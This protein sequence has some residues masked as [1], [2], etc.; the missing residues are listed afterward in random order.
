VPAGANSMNFWSI[1]SSCMHKCI[2]LLCSSSMSMPR[3]YF[4]HRNLDFYDFNA[5]IMKLALWIKLATSVRHSLQIYFIGL[6]SEMQPTSKHLTIKKN[7][8]LICIIDHVCPHVGTWYMPSGIARWYIYI[9][10]REWQFW[11][12]VGNFLMYFMTI[13]GFYDHFG[14]VSGQFV[15]LLPFLY[16]LHILFCCTEKTLETLMPRFRSCHTYH[17]LHQLWTKPMY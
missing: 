6:V 4:N 1:W 11:P 17:N 14:I 9:S 3:K 13:W 7:Y 15:F 16:I 2:L 10:Y 12:R 5:T 8:N